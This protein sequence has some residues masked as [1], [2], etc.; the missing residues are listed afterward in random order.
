[1]D[2]EHSKPHKYITQKF[3]TLNLYVSKL[4]FLDREIAMHAIAITSEL[5][6][7]IKFYYREIYYPLRLQ[8]YYTSSLLTP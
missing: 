5:F 6:T 8:I 1:M 3:Q 4:Q 2:E 7:I